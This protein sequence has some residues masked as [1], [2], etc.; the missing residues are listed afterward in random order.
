A[1]TYVITYNVS[2]NAG[3]TANEINRIVNVISLPTDAIVHE[4]Y[5]ESGWDGWI[6][7]GSDC[8]RLSGSNSYEGNFSIQLRDN[9][10]VASS[11]TSPLFNLS[12]F[13]EVEFSF[14]FYANSMENGEDFWLQ[15]ND[16]SGFVTIDTW[17]RG[18][19]FNNN[20]FGNFVVTLNNS[21]Y[22]LSSNAQFRL[23]CDASGNNDQVYID[24]IIITGFGSSSYLAKS[25]PIEKPIIIDNPQ[26]DI[27]N[28][29][30]TIYPNPVKGNILNIKT[31]KVG[32]LNYRIINMFGQLIKTGNS[33]K[34]I[35]DNI[36]AGVYFIE[37]H[38]GNEIMTKKFIK[39]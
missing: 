6:D 13:N 32:N 8:A 38:D 5:F 35:I 12:L 33:S 34:I 29:V 17:A 36:E 18:S 14:Y 39:E 9:S 3:N 11:M 4:G 25:T 21:Q 24:Q 22:N 10:G 1:G 23:L 2:D 28:N 30:L 15:Y 37:V 7:G 19:D 26:N 20:T 16:G 31:S 27:S